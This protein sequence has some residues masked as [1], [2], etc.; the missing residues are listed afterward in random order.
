MAIDFPDTSPTNE[1]FGCLE[2]SFKHIHISAWCLL[3]Q[4]TIRSDAIVESGLISMSSASP[5]SSASF[6]M[7]LA[8]SS[9][10]SVWD[11]CLF[12]SNCL[13]V[14]TKTD[15]ES[16]PNQ[17]HSFGWSECGIQHLIHFR[18]WTSSDEIDLSLLF[19]SH[20]EVCRRDEHLCWEI[21]FLIVDCGHYFFS[22]ILPC[23]NDFFG[24]RWIMVGEKH[25]VCLRHKA[26]EE[27]V[28]LR[29]TTQATTL[30][31]HSLYWWK[32]KVCI[33]ARSWS[34]FLGDH[35]KSIGIPAL[36]HALAVE[37]GPH[38]SLGSLWPAV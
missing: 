33:V 27:G 19:W 36:V 8:E 28:Q 6:I 2:P 22:V 37:A 38:L 23:H 4:I 1:R 29:T 24:V 18:S 26:R 34:I 7:I 13:K 20:V 5:S 3:C 30:S 15:C 10:W 35:N 9:R 21:T 16:Y 32:E 31:F 11:S 25:C 17:N 12:D 14:S